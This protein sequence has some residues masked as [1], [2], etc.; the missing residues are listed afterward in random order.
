LFKSKPFIENLSLHVTG[1]R[2]GQNIDYEKL[3][4]S[5]LPL[6]PMIEQEAIVRFLDH[7]DRRIRRYIRAK[8]KLIKLL[9]EQREAVINRAVTQGLDP[10]V[11]LKPSGISWLGDVPAHWEVLRAKQLCEAIIDCKNRTPDEVADGEFL[12]IR[13][14]CI[15][16]G[17]FSM[18]GSYRTDRQ[19]YETWT[20]RGAPRLGDVFFTREAPAGEACLVPS[21]PNI[22]MGQRMM[23]LRPDAEI[24]DPEFLL[25]SIYGPLV[26]GYVDQATN[27]STVGHLRLGQVTSIPL[28][29]CPI[30]EQ[31]E[32]VAHIR[33]T[34]ATID[35]TVSQG[36]REIALIREYRTRLIADVVTGKLDVRDA[37]AALPEEVDELTAE[38]EGEIEDILSGVVEEDGEPELE[39][40]EA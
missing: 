23:Y 11:R 19:S 30:R 15:R 20:Q 17:I 8:L 6:P 25:Y 18:E 4:R 21:L 26:R 33:R 34:A 13:T 24:L 28:P 39:E 3:S 27:G 5:R 12:V 38:D 37:A 7:S 36:E 32:V 1:I 31:R 40:V 22:C 35:P 16:D 10:E 29:W 14:T 2:Q 9:R